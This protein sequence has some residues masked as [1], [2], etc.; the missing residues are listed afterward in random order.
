M[1]D[2]LESAAAEA[3]A[4]LKWGVRRRLEFVEFRLYWEGRVNRRDLIDQFGISHQQATTDLERYAGIAPRNIRYDAGLRTFVRA[5]SFEPHLVAGNADRYLLQLQAIRL[6]WLDKDQT[7]FDQQPPLEVVSLRHRT[8]SDDVLRPVLDAI[9]EKSRLDI[10]YWTMSGKP[11]HRRIVDPHS[12]AFSAG[13]WHVRAWNEENQDFRD[14]NLTRMSS[15]RKLGPS[16]VD[17]KHDLEWNMTTRLRLAPNPGLSESE[18]ESVRREFA[19]SGS[20]LIVEIRLA[21][22]FYLIAEHNLDA[23]PGTP[24]HL[25]RLVLLNRDEASELRQAARRMSAAMTEKATD[26]Q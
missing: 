22:V 19:I 24:P 7:F 16:S 12:L 26:A 11:A 21:L 1:S 23:A 4:E 8:L 25:Q 17:S 20:E 15:V 3:P 14:F 9:R 5:E 13:R 18:Q 6:K 10:E 2:D